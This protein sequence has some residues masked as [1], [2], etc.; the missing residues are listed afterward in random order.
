MNPKSNFATNAYSILVR[1]GNIFS[2]LFLLAIRICWGW[3][4]FT[5]GRG[6]LGDLQKV[7]GFFHSLGIPLP[8]FNAVLASFTECFGGMLLLLGL[9]ARLVSVPLAITMLVAYL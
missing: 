9:G 5:T 4:F 1:S 7:T 6:K 2:H 8:K 3:Q